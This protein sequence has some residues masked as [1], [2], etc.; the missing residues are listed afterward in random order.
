MVKRTLT[1]GTVAWAT[2]KIVAGQDFNDVLSSAPLPKSNRHKS[3]VTGGRMRSV[4]VVVLIFTLVALAGASE[5]QHQNLLTGKVL[6]WDSDRS[7]VYDFFFG[8]RLQLTLESEGII[9][10]LVERD[11][12]PVTF[13][14]PA[15]RVVKFYRDW[16]GFLFLYDANRTKHRFAIKHKR[17]A[18]AQQK[19]ETSVPAASAPATSV[20]AVTPSADCKN[21]DLNMW[22]KMQCQQQA[23][24]P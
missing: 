14:P 12:D 22:E 20:P 9:Y 11:P 16:R 13:A 24:Q 1:S 7:G 3:C 23:K 18:D 21:G 6:D 8:Y 19:T 5:R 15:D 2:V 17:P 10:Q 4:S